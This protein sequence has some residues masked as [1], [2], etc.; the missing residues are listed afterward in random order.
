MTN[1]KAK[2]YGT[3][4]AS[5]FL[6]LYPGA[7]FSADTPWLVP[8]YSLLLGGNSGPS[9]KLVKDINPGVGDSD[10][11][12]L[13]VF[14]NLL[15]FGATDGVYG[16]EVWTSD[17]T[18][19]GTSLLKDINVGSGDSNSYTT[20]YTIGWNREF[21]AM[22]GVLFFTATDGNH[23]VTLWKSD[24]T[25]G[26]TSEV[27]SNVTPGHL[28][29]FKDELYFSGTQGVGEFENTE[30][31]KS[32]GTE[33]GT[34]LVKDIS[35]NYSSYPGGEGGFTVF[36][37]E[38]YFSVANT[39]TNTSPEL[40]QLWKTDGTE[41]G[42]VAVK[43]GTA[44]VTASEIAVCN[45]SLYFM[46]DD[47]SGNELW[48][49]D[50]SSDGT[51]MLSEKNFIATPQSFTEYNGAL[52]FTADDGL[53]GSELWKLACSTDNTITKVKDINP[54][55]VDSNPQLMT[56]FNNLLYFRAIN[57]N[58]GEE[59]WRS[60]GTESGTILVKDINPG[61]EDSSPQGFTAYNGVFYISADDG[62]HGDELWSSDGTEA[63]TKLLKDINPGPD[64][65]YPYDFTVMNDTLFFTAEDSINGWELWKLQE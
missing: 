1:V 7:V 56:V 18:M 61:P 26:G 57:V 14:N 13:F 2:I 25:S 31:W 11:E 46:A 47:G 29:V 5:I 23:P 8:V 10:S 28:I 48:K 30:L 34:I 45:N 51:V 24:G 40:C 54:G 44:L 49:S 42:T 22:N 62:V 55:N 35:E 37:N 43:P 64:S 20:Y 32:D 63:G 58:S 41:G 36:N 6:S 12:E 15:Y 39:N 53:S 60:N 38:L 17:G 59:L 3:F 9:I 27:N 19:A 65:S 4:F 33:E 52:Y 50:G 21:T 16:N